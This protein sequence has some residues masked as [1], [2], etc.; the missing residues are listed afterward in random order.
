MTCVEDSSR[1]HDDLRDLIAETMDE[2]PLLCSATSYT[3]QTLKSNQSYNHTVSRK[4]IKCNM[5]DDA[6]LDIAV[7]GFWEWCEIA[8]FDYKGF[9][10]CIS[11]Y[12][13][14]RTKTANPVHF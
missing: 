6:R 14:N 11:V 13:L 4:P 12:T 9:L 7:C 10:T 1:R 3:T 2:V 5:S 8:F